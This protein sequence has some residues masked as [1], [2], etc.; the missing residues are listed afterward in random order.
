M[1]QNLSRCYCEW[2][3]VHACSSQNALLSNVENIQSQLRISLNATFIAP[4]IV[5][6]NGDF[7]SHLYPQA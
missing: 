6:A 5:I 7:E 4:N 2:T 3:I 1:L